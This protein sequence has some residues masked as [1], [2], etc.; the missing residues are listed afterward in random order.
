MLVEMFILAR[1]GIIVWVEL[2]AY[3]E[4]VSELLLLDS[5]EVRPHQ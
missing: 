3:D 1:D 2:I 4:V 5:G